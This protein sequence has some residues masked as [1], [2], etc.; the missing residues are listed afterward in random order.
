MFN[1]FQG[2][3]NMV[4]KIL[5]LNEVIGGVKLSRSSIYLKISKGE[6]PKPIKLSDR[7]IGWVESEIDEWIDEQIQK[8]RN[9][10]GL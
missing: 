9:G 7:A 8:S 5:K 3:A 2:G 1:S 4:N 10:S 6:F